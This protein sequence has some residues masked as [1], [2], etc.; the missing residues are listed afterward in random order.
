MNITFAEN[1]PTAGFAS[2][3]GVFEDL[4]SVSA[5]S[6][7]EIFQWQGS[8]LEKVGYKNTGGRVMATAIPA[9]NVVYSAEWNR[10]RVYEYGEISGPD[11]DISTRV[12]E[13]PRL[14]IGESD[15]AYATIYN[16]GNSELEFISV[17]SNEDEF[18][19]TNPPAFLGPGD[20]VALE[21]VYHVKSSSARGQI[22]F[23]TNDPDDDVTSIRVNGNSSGSIQAGV[24]APNFTL[25]VIA[26]EQDATLELEE[27]RSDVVIVVFFASW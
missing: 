14:E 11:L 6:E 20:S 13:F 23:V 8:S 5:W 10:L 24:P 27:L 25:P 21:I 16:N 18:T 4:V 3:V 17:G 22:N 15:T 12:I 7:I 2:R 9:R 1:H 19:L 26:N